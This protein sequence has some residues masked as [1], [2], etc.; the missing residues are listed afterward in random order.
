MNSNCRLRELGQI[1][2]TPV[3]KAARRVAFVC[4]KRAFRAVPGRPGGGCKLDLGGEADGPSGG[5]PPRVL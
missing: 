2:R 1:P 3:S 4:S 5:I